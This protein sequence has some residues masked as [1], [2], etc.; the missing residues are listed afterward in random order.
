MSMLDHL[1]LKNSVFV[2]SIFGKYDDSWINKNFK[3]EG[4]V[5]HIRYH[6]I[7]HD[8]KHI[9][10]ERV[11]YIAFMNL[12]AYNNILVQGS[13][14]MSYIHDSLLPYYI[15]NIIR[16]NSNNICKLEVAIYDDEDIKKQFSITYNIHLTMVDSI[17][18]RDKMYDIQVI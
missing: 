10:K 17:L 11:F 3:Y 15:V 13:I 16:D 18:I 6:Y 9:G 5:K 12:E 14:I 1:S 8:A 2:R 4:T 7:N